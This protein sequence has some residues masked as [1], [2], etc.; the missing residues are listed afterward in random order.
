MIQ[1]LE[2]KETH[3]I[4]VHDGGV[5]TTT[6]VWDILLLESGA[7][8]NKSDASWSTPLVWAC[9]KDHGEIKRILLEAGAH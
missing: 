3:P 5:S 6:E 9:K 7:D 2:M 1:P 8:A 4:K